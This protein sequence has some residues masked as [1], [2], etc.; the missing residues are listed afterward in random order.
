[1]R[2]VRGIMEKRTE[3]GQSSQEDWITRERCTGLE[4]V[5]AG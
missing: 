2:E 4:K 3:R 1:M 5:M